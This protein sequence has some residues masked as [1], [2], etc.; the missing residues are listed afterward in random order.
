MTCDRWIRKT[1]VLLLMI[2]GMASPSVEADPPPIVN[3]PA[4]QGES[5]IRDVREAV[6]RESAQNLARHLLS[7]QMPPKHDW[8]RQPPLRHK[9]GEPEA[10][11]GGLGYGIS[12]DDNALLW[13]NSTIADYYVIAPTVL[14]GYVSSLYLTSTCRAQLGTESLI[15]YFEQ[16]EASFWVYDWAQGNH[17]QV[18]LDNLPATHPEY[19][20]MRPDEFGLSRQMCHIRN[21]TFY[22]GLSGGLYHW[23]NQVMLFNFSRDGWDLIY[24]YSYTTTSLAANLYTS[25]GGGWW[26]PIVETF[27]TYTNVNPVGFDLIRL[28]QDGNPNP[29]WIT[30]NNSTLSQSSPWQLLTL[31]TNTSFTVAVSS[32]NLAVGSYNLGTL[33]VTATTNAAF[34]LLHPTAG[35]VSAYWVLTP[36]SNTWDRTVVGLPPGEYSINF[37]TVPGLDTPVP[38]VFAI[39]A[40]S[41]TTVQAPYAPT[42]LVAPAITGQAMPPGGAFQTTFTGPPGQLFSVRG[43]NLLTAPMTTWPVLTNGTFGLSGS[44]T[45]TDPDASTNTVRYYRISSP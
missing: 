5:D 12:F 27:D 2:V 18:G 4:R 45:F 19:L 6:A 9:K 35:M 33:C 14:D 17:W 16:A 28:F 1:F 40:D 3:Q 26:G 32:T 36:N 30:P 43:T 34:F 38:Q 7:G 39:A 22:Q 37:N 8:R 23:Q 13:T 21:G 41:I 29:L 10:T 24:S 11:P 42:L 25:G 44:V 15:S 20:T 31:A